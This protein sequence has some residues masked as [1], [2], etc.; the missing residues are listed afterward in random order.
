[1]NIS[2]F[3]LHQRSFKIDWG[4]VENCHQMKWK[5]TPLQKRWTIQL[6]IGACYQ[7]P[8]SLLVCP[9]V[10]LAVL[11]VLLATTVDL[12]SGAHVTSVPSILITLVYSYSSLTPHTVTYTSTCTQHI[13]FNNNKR[14]SKSV[15]LPTPYPG[16]GLAVLWG[17]CVA[18]MCIYVYVC[19]YVP[20][21]HE[22]LGPCSQLVPG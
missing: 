20:G 14:G 21:D 17:C 8:A 3:S 19:V 4:K 18:W 6:I 5:L 16:R 10:L 13:T 2:N 12:P 11:A 15:G 22:H 7:K 9:S 1:M